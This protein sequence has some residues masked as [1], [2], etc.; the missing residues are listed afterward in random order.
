MADFCRYHS[1]PRPGT[2]PITDGTTALD[3]LMS[4]ADHP[5]APQVLTVVLDAHFIGHRGMVVHG[6]GRGA[7]KRGR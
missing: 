7:S 2:D 4:M 3:L 1:L 6:A 5:L